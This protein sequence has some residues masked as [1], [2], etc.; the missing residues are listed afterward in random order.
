MKYA[1]TFVFVVA[2]AGAGF[3]DTGAA[4]RAGFRV[5]D[6]TDVCI[7]NCSEENASCKRLCP[8]T[9]NVPCASACD[10]QARVCRR[11]CQSK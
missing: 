3:A 7:M 9:F 6:A 5:A 1:L 8:T 2:L 10:N 4:K 11:G